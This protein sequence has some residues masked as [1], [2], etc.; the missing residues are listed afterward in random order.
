MEVFYDA[1][2]EHSRRFLTTQYA[3]WYSYFE[4]M[5][6]I[7]L[8]P[9]GNIKDPQHTDG[10]CVSVNKTSSCMANKLQAVIIDKYSKASDD[11]DFID[12]SLRMMLFINCLSASANFTKDLYSIGE[13]CLGQWLPDEKW[14][15]LQVDLSSPAGNE[16]FKAA[17]EATKA[18]KGEATDLQALPWV[19]LDG[20]KHSQR[21]SGDLMQTVCKKFTD[22]KPVE[23]TTTTLEVFYSALDEP[24]HKFFKGQLLPMFNKL[25]ER[26]NLQLIP[27]GVP[28]AQQTLDQE[29][30]GK[31][32]ETCLHNRIH[33]SDIFAI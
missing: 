1:F 21:A 14:F 9:A 8:V 27:F 25:R 11:G 18:I 28:H 10:T 5:A 23:C 2:E 32:E 33:V 16:V 4:E 17:I 19:T 6:T 24:F 7:H 3:P 20:T 13:D 31:L 29:C 30:A 26:V 12:G 22:E 15:D